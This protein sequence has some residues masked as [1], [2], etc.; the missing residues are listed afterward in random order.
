MEQTKEKQI[1]EGSGLSGFDKKLSSAIPG[2]TVL[3]GLATPGNECQNN[4]DRVR[5]AV[6]DWLTGLGF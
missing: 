1:F 5:K 4:Q 6:N 2:S 3:K